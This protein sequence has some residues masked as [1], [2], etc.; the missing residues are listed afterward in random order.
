ML[1]SGIYIKLNT[2]KLCVRTAKFHLPAYLAYVST[3][4]ADGFGFRM[5]VFRGR[6]MHSARVEGAAFSSA[7]ARVVREEGQRTG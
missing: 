4:R 6:G 7:G 2:L 3:S 5:L 1:L